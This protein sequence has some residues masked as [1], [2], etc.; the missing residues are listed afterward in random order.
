MLPLKLEGI[1]GW[2]G[3]HTWCG[4][5]KPGLFIYLFLI[6]S[7]FISGTKRSFLQGLELMVILYPRVRAEVLKMGS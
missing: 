5:L 7:F 6:D 2:P 4:S 3:M 1:Q